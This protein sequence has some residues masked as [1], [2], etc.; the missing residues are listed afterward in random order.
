MDNLLILGAGG[1]SKVI[2]ETYMSSINHGN[3]KYLDD[4]YANI[5][6]NSN[7]IIGPLSKIYEKEIKNKF[8]KAI[9]SISDPK[10]RMY[11]LDILER[12][13]YDIKPIIHKNSFVSKTAKI[14][15]GSV[16]YAKACIQT[17]AK[18][19]RGVFIN[20]NSCIEHNSIIGNGV[21]ICPGTNIG[22]HVNIGYCSWIGI[23]SSIIQDIKIG[24]NVM[25]GAGS[26]V[27]TNI[28]NN[29]LA[30]GSPAKVIKNN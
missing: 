2:A 4:N 11:W 24:E 29:S 6:N 7:T 28:P 15:N 22:G 27:T 8:S 18:I 21:H 14:D 5:K 19:G 20:T 9:I 23:G 10:I 12:E 25:I 26:V 1:N 3:I 13:N 17:E 30:V 16:I